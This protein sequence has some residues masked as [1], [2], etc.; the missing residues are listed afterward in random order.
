MI[1]KKLTYGRNF[2]L[3]LF[4]LGKLSCYVNKQLRK[5]LKISVINMLEGCFW[6]SYEFSP[7]KIG[8]WHLLLPCRVAFLIS[9]IC[10]EFV[11]RIKELPAVFSVAGSYEENKKKI[12]DVK[13]VQ[14]TQESWRGDIV[15]RTYFF[16]H[17]LYCLKSVLPHCYWKL[18]IFLIVFITRLTKAVIKRFIGTWM[19]W[20]CIHPAFLSAHI[21]HI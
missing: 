16:C 9:Y 7:L 8:S 12:K 21:A 15:D 20:D 3:S 11:C 10:K 6:S 5:F 18:L 17:I 2:F 1:I 4:S 13:V 19:S 14:G